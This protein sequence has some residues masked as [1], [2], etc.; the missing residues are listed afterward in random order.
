MKRK[1]A[2]FVL[3]N[4]LL[5]VAVKASEVIKTVIPQRVV[6]PASEVSRKG[7][8][9]QQS[10][11]WE[12]GK[13]AQI[14]QTKKLD[15]QVLLYKELIDRIGPGQAQEE[16]FRSG[17]SFDGQ[18]HLLNHTVG[19]VLYERYGTSGLRDCKD[20]FLSS[21]YHGFVIRAVGD[22][23]S[24][25][26]VGVMEKCWE[27]GNHVAIQC[28]HAIGHG[29]LAWV[30]Y[31]NL[32]EAIK[33]CDDLSTR[34][35]N[36]P[37]Y[38]CHDGAFMENIWAVH[39]TG[40]PSKDR[41]LN[42]A[43]PIYPCNDPRIPYQYL[44][45]CWSN[46]PMRLYQLFQGDLRRVGLVCL[47]ITDE[48]HRKTCFDGL[49]R[50]IHPL[51][52]GSVDETFLMCSTMPQGWVTPCIVSIARA[53]FSVGDRKVPFDICARMLQ[54]DQGSCYQGL[55]PTIHGYIINN[56]EREEVCGNITDLYWR[57]KCLSKNNQ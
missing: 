49:A 42:D 3:L 21:C 15:E 55:I 14:K 37:V 54:A 10:R 45:A 46:Q 1:I 23:G 32:L 19:D 16:L 43:D 52:K 2:A 6:L 57:E 8:A 34:S 27:E 22:G 50:Q 24:D 39:E 51:T 29:F 25:A 40:K 41:W 20:Y 53:A 9:E 56:R 31:A 30:G 17:L 47:G 12:V 48:D 35:K 28:S 33:D 26:L 18:T 4:F 7:E 11:A 36:F 38:N 5:I 13:I 44:K